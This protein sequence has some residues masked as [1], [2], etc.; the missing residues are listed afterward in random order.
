MPDFI[1]DFRFVIYGAED[2]VAEDGAIAVEQQRP[3]FE[4]L[5]LL[6]M[7]LARDHPDTVE[8]LMVVDVPAYFS[9]LITLS[10]LSC[11]TLPSTKSPYSSVGTASSSGSKVEKLP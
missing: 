5:D 8:R 6:G 1:L 3:E 7:I 11:R 10:R 9:V 4:E 2:L